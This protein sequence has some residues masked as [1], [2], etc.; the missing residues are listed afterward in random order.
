MGL[1]MLLNSSKLN[2][3]GLNEHR[4]LSISFIFSNLMEYKFLKYSFI[5]LWITFLLAVIFLCLFISDSV[6]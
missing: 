6:N 1:S 4:N 3:G 5:I 2:L